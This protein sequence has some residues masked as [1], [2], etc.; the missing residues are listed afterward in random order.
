[1]II[2]PIMLKVLFTV[3]QICFHRL[4]THQKYRKCFMEYAFSVWLSISPDPPH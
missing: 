3:H 1:M 2:A 4:K